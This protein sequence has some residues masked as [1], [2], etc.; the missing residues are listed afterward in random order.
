MIFCVLKYFCRFQFAFGR[1]KNDGMI[2]V[3]VL[4]FPLFFARMAL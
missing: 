2:G 3:Q 1:K 4:S